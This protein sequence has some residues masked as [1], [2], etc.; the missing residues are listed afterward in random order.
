MH[1]NVHIKLHKL[2][3]FPMRGLVPAAPGEDAG[4]RFAAPVVGH[5]VGST[6]RGVQRSIYATPVADAEDV[7]LLRM[8]KILNE[9]I[10]IEQ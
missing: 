3:W 6:L 4:P 10:S 5:N 8:C 7:H 2:M 1:L 9:T